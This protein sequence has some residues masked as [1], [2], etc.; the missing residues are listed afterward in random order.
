MMYGVETLGKK[1]TFCVIYDSTALAVST[2][3]AICII[4]FPPHPFL[5]IVLW[6]VSSKV[7]IVEG[8]SEHKFKTVNGDGILNV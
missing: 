8:T 7:E 5:P 1:F 2:V 3:F 4:F 6:F